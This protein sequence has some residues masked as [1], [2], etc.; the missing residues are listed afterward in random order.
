MK[1]Y[2]FKA[3]FADKESHQKS[4][5]LHTLNQHIYFR[6]LNFKQINGIT[7]TYIQNLLK[8]NKKI[9]KNIIN[10]IF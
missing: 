2:F 1:H 9:K 5:K 6:T 8:K 7:R 10:S 3:E 4:T